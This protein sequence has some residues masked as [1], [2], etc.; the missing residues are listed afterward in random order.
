MRNA[1]LYFIALLIGSPAIAHQFSLDTSAASAVISAIGNKALTAEEAIRIAELHGNQMMIKKMASFGATKQRFAEELVA[2]AQGAKLEQ[3]LLFNFTS[4]QRDL[5]D[6]AETLRSIEGNKGEFIK[7]IKERVQIF[8]P[9]GKPLHLQGFMI[10]GGSSTGFAFG[11]DFYL[12]LA[13]FPKDPQAAQNTTAHELYHSVQAAKLQ[14]LGLAEKRH[15]REA[16]YQALTEPQERKRYVVEGFLINLLNEG[17]AMYVADPELLTGQ[18]RYSQW[19]RG[20]LK[21]QQQR[22]D[23]LSAQLDLSLAAL[24]SDTPV[25]YSS[26][27]ALGFHGPDQP[28][29]YLGYAMAKAIALKK[30]NQRLAELI[31]GTGC[32]FTNEYLELTAGDSTLPALGEPTKRLVRTHCGN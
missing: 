28:L 6:V 5:P 19:D 31:T 11:R 7:Q 26:A 20:R 2:A 13:H 12:N 14:S 1:L 21:T 23:K 25:P 29:Y 18:G 32:Q 8:S 10:A 9:P 27:Y 4:L 30:G 24:T 22:M 15:F 17:V 3:P 16:D